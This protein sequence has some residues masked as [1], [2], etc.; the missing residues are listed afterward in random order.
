MSGLQYTF[1]FSIQILIQGNKV[2]IWVRRI[3]NECKYKGFHKS[4]RRT[5]N[6]NKIN[7]G[8]QRV[9]TYSRD[10]ELESRS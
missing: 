3:A 1:F 6:K 10:K 7:E 9:N 8:I 5:V 2:S 4:K